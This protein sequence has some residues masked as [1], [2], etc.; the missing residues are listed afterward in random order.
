MPADVLYARTNADLKAAVDAYA[1][2]RDVSLNAAIIELVTRGLANA[3]AQDAASAK[4]EKL[5]AEKAKLV[6]QLTEYKTQTQYLSAF[7]EQVK[8]RAGA[9]PSPS[10]E[11][12]VTGLDLLRGRCPACGTALS[13]LPTASKPLDTQLL[14]LI[15]AVGLLAGVIWVASKA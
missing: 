15:G 11:K 2:R 9:C 5:E 3:A 4:L 13:S 14:S 8:G 12:P 1:E 6:R 10:C 7:A